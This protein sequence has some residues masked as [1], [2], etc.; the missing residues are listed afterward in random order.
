MRTTVV[1]EGA[2]RAGPAA[3]VEGADREATRT[4]VRTRPAGLVVAG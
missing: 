1:E 2:G 3:P 4:A